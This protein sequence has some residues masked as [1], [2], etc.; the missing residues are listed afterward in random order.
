MN[1]QSWSQQALFSQEDS[2]VLNMKL[3]LNQEAQTIGV[4][5]VMNKRGHS[6]PV[7]E[8]VGWH[9][10]SPTGVAAALFQMWTMIEDTESTHGIELPP[11][12]GLPDVAPF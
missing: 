2:V 4:W 10:Y 1:T 8:L 3:S 5:A 9:A 7:N 11:I 12:D 6:L